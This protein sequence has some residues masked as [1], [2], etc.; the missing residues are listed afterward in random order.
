MKE[1]DLASIKSVAKMLLYVDFKIDE[2]VPFI[3]HHPF[4]QNTTFFYREEGSIHCLDLTKPAE[5][6][7]AIEAVTKAIEE[8]TD[9]ASLYSLI[10]PPYWAV[11]FQFVQTY[12]SVS[13]YSTFLAHLWVH[14]EFPNRDADVKP[15]E[16]I[17]YFKKADKG[18]LMNAE[19]LQ[20]YKNLP[21]EILVYRGIG[22]GGS[23]KALS[24]TVDVHTAEWF[25]KRFSQ[26]PRVYRAKIKKQDVLAYFEGKGEDELVV[27]YRKLYLIEE[28]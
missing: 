7:R 11:F 20:F 4:F 10:K 27:D 28:I 21:D 16:M 18:L 13:D 19:E 15:Y 9:F 17:R 8:V 5:Y 25:S 24:W 23:I 22:D 26:S 3:I 12:L 1:T 14:M 6:S 2:R